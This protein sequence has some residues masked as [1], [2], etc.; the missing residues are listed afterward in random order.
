[1]LAMRD[2]G[3]I[4]ES[5]VFLKIDMPMQLAKWPFRLERLGTDKTFDDVFGFRRHH[6][7][8]GLGAGDVDR[9]AGETA[10]DR[11]FIEIVGD[12]VAASIRHDR[13]A[14]DNDAGRH[15]LATLFVFAA[16]AGRCPAENQPRHSSLE[17]AAL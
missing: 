11:D 16:N 1:M 13:R 17:A 9:P 6:D 14:A 10:G 4:H 15:R 3:D 7:V 2:R 5:V 8:H 12:L